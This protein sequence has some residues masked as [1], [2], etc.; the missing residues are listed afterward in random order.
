MELAKRHEV[1]IERD[2]WTENLPTMTVMMMIP[3]IMWMSNDMLVVW[4]R[5]HVKSCKVQNVGNFIQ[6]ISR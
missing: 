2:G 5:N 3:M 4:E 6:K 1:C